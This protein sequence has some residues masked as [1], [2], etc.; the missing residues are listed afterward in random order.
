MPAGQTPS[1]ELPPSAGS[2]AVIAATVEPSLIPPSALPPPAPGDARE[3]STPRDAPEA[4]SC[5]PT[6]DDTGMCGD[7]LAWP[8]DPAAKAART[9]MRTSPNPRLFTSENIGHDYKASARP[10][11]VCDASFSPS[12]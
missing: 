1:P 3:T 9:T 10:C 5:E 8:H 11:L 4:D 6:P 2:T 12:G 7:D